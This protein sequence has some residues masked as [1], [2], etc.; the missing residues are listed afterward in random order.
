MEKG[1][2]REGKTLFP[3]LSFGSVAG[4]LQII[5]KSDINRRKACKFYLMLIF[6]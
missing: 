6:M 3:L 4:A 5:L 2:G 1:L